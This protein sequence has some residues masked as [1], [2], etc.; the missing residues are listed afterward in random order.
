MK[1]VIGSA[2]MIYLNYAKHPKLPPLC[3]IL[4]DNFETLDTSVWTHEVDLGGFGY[5]PLCHSPHSE[6]LSDGSNGQFEMATSSSSN[7]YAKDGKLYI[8]PTLTSDEI[9][10]DAI[11]DG[12]TFN[13]TDCTNK[14]LDDDGQ[15]ID[16]PDACGK[17]SNSSTA[18]IIPPVMSARLTTK[19]R[20]S[21]Q[22]GKV[23]VVAKLPRG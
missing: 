14:I 20:A 23:S 1:G 9:G 3:L 17:V 11:L 16:N 7:S 13:L 22:Y 8:T 12:Y 4:E 18:T 15:E 2:A 10:R 19:K 21:I 5:V 6:G